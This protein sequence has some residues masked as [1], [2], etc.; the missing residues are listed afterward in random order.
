[1]TAV[2]RQSLMEARSDTRDER[3]FERRVSAFIR[4]T[5]GYWIFDRP[6]LRGFSRSGSSVDKDDPGKVCF[7]NT[8]ESEQ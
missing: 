5:N 1:M 3:A 8:R 2:P 7:R 4:E 6:F